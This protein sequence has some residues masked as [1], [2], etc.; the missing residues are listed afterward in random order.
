LH[1]LARSHSRVDYVSGRI[2]SYS[3]QR[4]S[5]VKGNSLADWRHLDVARHC[6]YMIGLTMRKAKGFKE[7]KG[8]SAV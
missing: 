3:G 8:Q 4:T 2:I 6:N 7:G 1:I 5:R